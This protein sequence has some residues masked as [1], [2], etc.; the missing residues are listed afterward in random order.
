MPTPRTNSHLHDWNIDG[1][2]YGVRDPEC[3]EVDMLD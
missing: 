1:K 3:N 2:R